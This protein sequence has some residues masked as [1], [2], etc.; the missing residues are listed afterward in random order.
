[1]KDVLWYMRDVFM[2]SVGNVITP[3]CV[4]GGIFGGFAALNLLKRGVSTVLVEQYA[5]AHNH[6]SSHGDGRM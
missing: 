2:H 6:G 5:E 4:G 3:V 1:M